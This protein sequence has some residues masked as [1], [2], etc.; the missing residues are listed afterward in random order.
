[1]LLGATAAQAM[2]G[3]KFKV[4]EM[5]GRVLT[6]PWARHVIATVHPSSVLRAPGDEQR[7]AARLAFFAD[8]AVVG[9]CYRSIPC[10]PDTPPAVSRV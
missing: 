4:T 2:L 8:V 10:T 7:R 6:A 3:S 5:R 9:E 1:V